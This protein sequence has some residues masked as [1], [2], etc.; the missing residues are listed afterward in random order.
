MFTLYI[1]DAIRRK[2]PQGK[3]MRSEPKNKSRRDYFVNIFRIGFHYL[4]FKVLLVLLPLIQSAFLLNF[5]AF[6]LVLGF[7]KMDNPLIK[8]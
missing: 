6:S 3:I 5:Y 8:L 1:Y 7:K 2:A 4:K